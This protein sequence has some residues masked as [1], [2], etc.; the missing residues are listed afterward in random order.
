AHAKP[1]M[2]GGIQRALTQAAPIVQ[3]FGE[4][5]RFAKVI[6]HARELTDRQERGSQIETQIDRLLGALSAL[7][8]PLDRGKRT[9]EKLGGFPVGRAAQ[10]LPARLPQILDGALP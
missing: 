3:L 4:T 6:R 2:A 1:E 7:R 5:L 9:L 10:G 8:Q